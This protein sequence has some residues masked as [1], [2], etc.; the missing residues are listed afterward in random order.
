MIRL[1][2]LQPY[3]DIDIIFSGI[4]PGEKLFEELEITGENLLKTRHPKIFIGKIGAY[5]HSEVADILSNFRQAVQSSD[6]AKIRALF[7]HFLPEANITEK[8]DEQ[9]VNKVT[10]TPPEN[11]INRQQS[12]LET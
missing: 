6:K 8:K 10:I 12:A 2:G 9:P 5:E 1:S 11:L 7:N 3:E 4:R